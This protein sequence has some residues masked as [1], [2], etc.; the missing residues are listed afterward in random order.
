[1]IHHPSDNPDEWRQQ[2]QQVL[3]WA[4]EVGDIIHRMQKVGTLRPVPYTDR[5]EMFDG[6]GE[7][8]VSPKNKPPLNDK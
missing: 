2:L 5:I 6:G 8:P 3:K 7:A 1:L 4:H